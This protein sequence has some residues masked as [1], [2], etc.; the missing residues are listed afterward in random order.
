MTTEKEYQQQDSIMILFWGFYFGAIGILI[1]YNFFSYISNRDSVYLVY[2]FFSVAMLLNSLLFD[3]LKAMTSEY[4]SSIHS[5]NQTISLLVLFLAVMF[6]EIFLKLKV[7]LP[8]WFT[9]VQYIKFF[10]VLVFIVKFFLHESMAVTI[11]QTIVGIVSLIIIPVSYLSFKKHN[12]SAIIMFIAFII[13]ALSA[14]LANLNTYF[15]FLPEVF[16]ELVI[17]LGSLIE[18]FLM[19][20]A[21]TA[22]MS[23]MRNKYIKSMINYEEKLKNEV[24]KMGDKL[25]SEEKFSAMGR[26]AK[27]IAHE[28]NNPLM[29]LRGNTERILKITTDEKIIM[30]G[31]KCLNAQKRIEQITKNFLYLGQD[32]STMNKSKFN[33]CEVLNRVINNKSDDFFDHKIEIKINQCEVLMITANED[34]MSSVFNCLIE[35]SIDAIKKD[36][37]EKWIKF[38]VEETDNNFINI[39]IEDSGETPSESV[40]QKMF[41]PFFT[42]KQL[43]E[44]LGMSLANARTLLENHGGEITCM[45]DTSHTSFLVKLPLVKQAA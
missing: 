31:E 21:L 18:M 2:T 45:S 3:P 40:R 36:Q 24:N 9:L 32:F 22:R 1:I 17:P 23:D 5:H 16:S 13:L 41:E 44:T 27:G 25:I 10:I 12:K 14:L 26:L 15:N 8:K 43:G 33:L 34:G 28:V 30:F 20:V 42:T 35:N 4:Y 19:S 37:G 29:I 38:T 39:L 6:S 11:T 7:L